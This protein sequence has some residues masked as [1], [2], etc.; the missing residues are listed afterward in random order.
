VLIRYSPER[1]KLN[2]E[3][4]HYLYKNLYYNPVVNAPHL[5]AK[6][7]LRDLF[8]YCIAHPDQIGEHARRRIRRDGRYRAVCDYIS[9]MTDR[10]LMSEHAR[11]CGENTNDKV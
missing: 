11:L 3:L 4:R 7:M 10:Y 6:Q 2:L 5:R 1:R 9:G 8:R